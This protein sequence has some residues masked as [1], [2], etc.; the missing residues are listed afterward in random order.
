MIKTILMILSLST[1]SLSAFSAPVVISNLSGVDQLSDSDVKKLFLGK[2]KQLPNGTEPIVIEYADGT[3][4]RI[5]FHEKVTN[6]S[7]SQLQAYWAKLVFTGK[8]NPPKTV[9]SSAAAIAEVSQNAAAIGY[10][11]SSEVTDQ[12]KV[13]YTP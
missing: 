7:E 10:I 1:L 5:E 8:A 12:V 13:V 3:P 6:K 2:L 4:I 9:A 11:D